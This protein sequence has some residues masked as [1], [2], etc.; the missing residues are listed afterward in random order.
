M[1]YSTEGMAWHVMVC[2]AIAI[3]P[4]RNIFDQFHKEF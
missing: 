3:A 4:H 2:I 1:G